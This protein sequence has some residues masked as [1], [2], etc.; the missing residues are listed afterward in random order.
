ML[1]GSSSTEEESFFLKIYFD[2]GKKYEYNYDKECIW[3]WEKDICSA[4]ENEKWYELSF[5]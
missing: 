2:I 5:C 3:S 4:N 1:F